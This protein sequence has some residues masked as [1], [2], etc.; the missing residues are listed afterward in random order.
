M[1]K[2]TEIVDVT[3]TSP[4]VEVAVDTIVDVWVDVKGI[5]SRKSVTVY[6]YYAV[7]NVMYCVAWIVEVDLPRRDAWVG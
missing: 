1:F 2:Y 5:G 3:V 7:V 6:R 4:P